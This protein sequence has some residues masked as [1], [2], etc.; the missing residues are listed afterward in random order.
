M[1]Y[2]RPSQAAREKGV[3]IAAIMKAIERGALNA[4]REYGITLIPVDRKYRDY[5]PRPYP[6]RKKTSEDQGA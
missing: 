4:K 3:S 1:K 5:K 2:V 6:R